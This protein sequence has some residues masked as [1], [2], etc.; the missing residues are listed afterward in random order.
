MGDYG[1]AIM[2]YSKVVEY[3]PETKKGAMS[4]KKLD[5]LNREH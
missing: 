3:F 5:V 1:L 4:Q 2:Y